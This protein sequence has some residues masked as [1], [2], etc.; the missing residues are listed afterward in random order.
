MAF[1]FAYCSLLTLGATTPRAG[2][3]S[4]VLE[5]V[6]T[7]LLMSS[8][9]ACRPVPRRRID[10][11]R[12]CRLDHRTG[13]LFA[14]PSAAS[15]NPAGRCL[16]LFRARLSFYGSTWSPVLG[17]SS[18]RRA[19]GAF[20]NPLLPPSLRSN[21]QAAQTSPCAWKQQPQ[22]DGRSLC[23]PSWGRWVKRSVLAAAVGP[24]HPAAAEFMREGLRPY[25]ASLKIARRYSGR[26]IRRGGGHGLRRRRMPA[27]EGAQTRRMGY[28]GSQESASR[29]V[30]PGARPGRNQGQGFVRP[31]LTAT[32]FVAAFGV[33]LARPSVAQDAA[34]VD[35]RQNFE[36]P[37]LPSG[38]D[39][40]VISQLPS[41]FCVATRKST[42]R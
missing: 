41:G 4:F 9:S 19:A 28:T 40:E 11:R 23:P 31:A 22:P 27:S 35:R 24:R 39:R 6:L 21:P 26:R 1:S 14:G 29:R 10:G 33:S 42:A 17:R 13:A 30:S 37:G 20:T 7:F 12:R 15:M 38:V 8:F 36:L 3:Q 2:H 5:M 18:G 34:A 16:P 32:F 25:D